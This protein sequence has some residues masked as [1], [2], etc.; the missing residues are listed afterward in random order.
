MTEVASRLG[1]HPENAEIFH[2]LLKLAVTTS[3]YFISIRPKLMELGAYSSN[4]TD[5][6]N[7]MSNEERTQMT[8]A[9]LQISSGI[10]K[11]ISILYQAEIIKP[12]VTGFNG[13]IMKIGSFIKELFYDIT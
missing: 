2:S 13:K 1:V 8:E 5:P 7:S 9:I 12:D 4:D 11:Y 3:K 10:K 6:E